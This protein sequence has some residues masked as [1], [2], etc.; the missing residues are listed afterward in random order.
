MKEI[1]W[2]ELIL[3]TE[4]FIGRMVAFLKWILES[5]LQNCIH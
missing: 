3:N 5:A 4:Q 2:I 1:T